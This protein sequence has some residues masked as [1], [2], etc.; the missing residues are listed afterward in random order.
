[1]LAVTQIYLFRPFSLSKLSLRHL[2]CVTGPLQAADRYAD[3]FGFAV[4]VT[5]ITPTLPG[6]RNRAT[7][8]SRS[9]RRFFGFAV[10]VTQITHSL[11]GLRNRATPGSRSLRRFFRFCCFRYA[12]YPTLPGLRNRAA[13]D[14]RMLRGKQ[15]NLHFSVTRPSL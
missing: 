7:P 5:Q 10:F 12:D 13:L 9:L 6:L 1:M 4:F 11:P 3:F 8:G 15:K 14:G 2:V